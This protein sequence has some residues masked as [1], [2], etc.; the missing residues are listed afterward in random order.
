LGIEGIAKALRYTMIF[1]AVKHCALIHSH[2]ELTADGI[3]NCSQVFQ[4]PQACCPPSNCLPPVV[5][6]A[7]IIG[8]AGMRATLLGDTV[9]WLKF[10]KPA[11]D[12]MGLKVSG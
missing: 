12:A 7:Q 2:P 9:M 5:S 1:P 3:C 11:A 4:S 8:R 10:G 6:L